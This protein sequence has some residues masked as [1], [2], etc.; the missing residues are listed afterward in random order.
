MLMEQSIVQLRQQMHPRKVADE[1][2]VSET[3]IYNIKS[4]VKWANA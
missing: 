2:G 1:F 3:L 4:G